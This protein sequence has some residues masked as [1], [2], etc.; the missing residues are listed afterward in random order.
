MSYKWEIIEYRCCPVCNKYF[1]I[2][3]QQKRKVYCDKCRDKHY[4]ELRASYMDDPD[5]RERRK[6]WHKKY[7]KAHRKYKT[8]TCALCGKE[9]QTGKGGKPK[10]C[11]SC[12]Y[13]HRYENPYREYY[14][15][16]G[17]DI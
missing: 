4:K 3:A 9:F 10:Y 2:N 1:G 17:G 13:E 14:L 12:L 5:Y 7:R 11:M 16:R 6:A 8:Y 15:S